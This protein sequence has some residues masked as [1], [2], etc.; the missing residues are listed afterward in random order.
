MKRSRGD[1]RAS[2]RPRVFLDALFLLAAALCAA[3]LL[4]AFVV[5]S[6]RI[7]TGSMEP[8]LLPGDAVLVSK[9]S[10]GAHSPDVLSALGLPRFR[11]PALSPLRRGDVV[12]ARFADPSV[13]P[14]GRERVIIKRCGALP[15][16]LVRIT[17]EGVRVNELPAAPESFI[18]PARGSRLRLNQGTIG[19]WRDLVAS[20]GHD[21]AVNSAGEI[22]IDGVVREEYTVEHDYLYLLGDNQERSRDSRAWGPVRA[23]ALIGKVAMIYW[24]ADQGSG[25]DGSFLPSVRWSRIG[26]LVR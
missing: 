8:T 20:E 23:E 10:Y 13:D 18:V 4:R 15:G 11:L 17:A 14:G 16:D 1:G 25:S 26:S 19:A 22:V 21:I 12:A 24:S 5:E 9:L 6:Y 7:S 3:A 2:R